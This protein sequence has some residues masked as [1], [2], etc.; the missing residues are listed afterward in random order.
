MAAR[1]TRRTKTW[2]GEDDEEEELARTRRQ[3]QG[4]EEE[5][6]ARTWRHNAVRRRTSR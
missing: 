5:E 1:T 2:R 3:R 4:K 6:L